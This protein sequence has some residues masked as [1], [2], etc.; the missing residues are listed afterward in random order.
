LS[1]QHV[2][3]GAEATVEFP[4]PVVLGVRIAARRE[5][6]EPAPW[7]LCYSPSGASDS[8]RPWRPGESPNRGHVMLLRLA[9]RPSIRTT[10][11]VRYALLAFL[12][13]SIKLATA[14]QGGGPSFSQ[15]SFDCAKARSPLA[16]LICSGEET[17]RA[18][19][20]LRVASWAR[21]F[22]LDEDERATFWEE[23]DQWLRSV[24]QKCRLTNSPPFSRQQ[25]A[26]VIEAYM[27]RAA[28]YRSRLTGA[29]LGESK[30]SE[31]REQGTVVAAHLCFHPSCSRCFLSA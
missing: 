22:S 18:D 6:A 14:A 13:G 2:R 29:A 10:V 19:W 30:L 23:Q 25:S 20:D 3:E 7:R 8:L 11:M 31:N 4:P 21:Y 17:A 15:P 24:N 1:S 12:L 27:A 5:A 9:M 16:L 26:C 28:L